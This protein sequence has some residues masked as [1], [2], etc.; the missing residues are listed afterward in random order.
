MTTRRR[1]LDP[2][3]PV[4]P[5]RPNRMAGVAPATAAPRHGLNPHLALPI[6]PP[7]A[8]NVSI[9][10]TPPPELE[11]AN[12]PHEAPTVK[13]RRGADKVSVETVGGR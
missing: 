3:R 11:A 4:R 8:A 12:P 10:P 5:Q 2:P 7:L 13:V 1:L 9:A 6:R